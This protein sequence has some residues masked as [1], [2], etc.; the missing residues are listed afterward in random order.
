MPFIE[1]N[2]PLT[3]NKR[4]VVYILAKNVRSQTVSLK[5]LWILLNKG[6]SMLKI[7]KL[8]DDIASNEVSVCA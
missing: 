8:Y 4:C 3:V 1:N 7:P 2:M 5:F 6:Y